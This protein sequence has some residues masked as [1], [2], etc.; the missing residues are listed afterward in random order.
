[1]LGSLLLASVHLS[2]EERL[3]R[4]FSL[5]RMLLFANHHL[6]LSVGICWNS[7]T[8]VEPAHLEQEE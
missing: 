8:E 4:S 2:F 7:G 5:S 1:M 3:S 6:T